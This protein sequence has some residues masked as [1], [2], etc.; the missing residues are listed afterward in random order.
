MGRDIVFTNKYY[1]V[2]RCN[3]KNKKIYYTVHNRNKVFQD[4]HAHVSNM[5]L[6]KLVVYTCT[7]GEIP[8]GKER[9]YSDL[10]FVESLC[11]VCTNSNKNKFTNR[12]NELLMMSETQKEG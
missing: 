6:A 1:R 7:K 5:G 2:Y 12:Y 10:R 8:H 4:G 11:R 3:T 9:L